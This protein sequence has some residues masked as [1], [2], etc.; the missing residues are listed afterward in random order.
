MI[1][2][3][4]PQLGMGTY[5]LQ[6]EVAYKSVQMALDV[7]FR[8]IDTAQIY[9]NEEDVGRAIAES[10]VA[11]NDVFITT[12]VWNDKLSQ[13]EFLPSVKQSLEKLKTDYVDLVL[14][15]WP[16]PQGGEPMQEYLGELLKAQQE[17]LAKQIGV[18]NFTI[19]QTQQALDILPAGALATNQIEVHPYLTNDA[20]RDYCHI[21][22]V[23]VT[24][25]M[26]FAVGKV[27]QDKTIISIAEKYRATPA[28]IVLAWSLSQD[29]VT[30]PS[31]TKR[32]NLEANFSAQEIQLETDDVAAISALNCGDR[33]A[34]PDFS[35]EWNQ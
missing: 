27:L 7:G 9:G 22:Q 2:R 18:S 24:G 14:I 3:S 29:M 25:Y 4:I 11:R 21:N 1:N 13:K 17:G 19:A 28:Q 8:H 15:H 12:K 23:Q 20:L 34:N 5:R 32:G 6:G 30:I 35:P 33:Q 16:S 31:S 10:S 26:P